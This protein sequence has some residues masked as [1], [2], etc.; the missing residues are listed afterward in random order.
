MK[1]IK[2]NIRKELDLY[3]KY[4][5]EV[6]GE[7]LKYLIDEAKVK[8]D[9]EVVINTKLNIKNIDKLI[10]K[11]LTDTYND[12]RKIDKIYDS[13]QIILFIIGIIFLTISTL[14][15]PE[16]VKEVILIIGWVFVWEVLDIT[17]NIDSKQKRQKRIIKKLLNCQIKV[18]ND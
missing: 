5:D 6:S 4:S 15:Q 17:I 13:K 8:D 10:I 12:I 16:I 2:V 14:T 1:T 11:G 3:E 9:V 18:N 7:L